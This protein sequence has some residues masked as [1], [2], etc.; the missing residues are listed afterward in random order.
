M[1]VGSIKAIRAPGS[2]PASRM[3]FATARA[4]LLALEEATV[5]LNVVV[6]DDWRV[7]PELAARTDGVEG[8]GRRR[9]VWRA[10]CAG[11]FTWAQLAVLLGR[12]GTEAV[13]WPV[14]VMQKR[15]VSM[16]VA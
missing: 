12:L 8:T 1:L 11:A 2:T 4:Q 14:L 6:A 13:V 9:D 15:K 3:P 5:A 16:M 10:S 7:H